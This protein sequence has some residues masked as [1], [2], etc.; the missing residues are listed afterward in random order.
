MQE[1]EAGNGVGGVNY[2]RIRRARRR[3]GKAEKT[4]MERRRD[5]GG[6]QPQM[7]AMRPDGRKRVMNRR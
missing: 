3:G 5:D 6:Q 4:P 7:D 1:A 2:E